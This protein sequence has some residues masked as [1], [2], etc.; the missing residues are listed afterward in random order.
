M[1]VAFKLQ[2]RVDG[3][4]PLRAK[5]ALLR[6]SQQRRI[7]RPAVA[8]AGT[9]VLQAARQRAP[10]ESGQLRRS[11]GKRVKLLRKSGIVVAI[12]GPRRKAFRKQLWRQSRWSKDAQWVNPT[13]YAHLVEF[14]TLPHAIG[15]GRRLVKHPGAR[16]RP[17]L[18]P[19]LAATR[20]TVL[21]ILTTKI[22][23]GLEKLAAAG[24]RRR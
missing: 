9:P 4:G 22:G 5:L 19:A 2:M 24:R 14:G 23:Q 17:F 13:N 15:V 6:A 3:L 8:A 16:A 12:V 18:R 20:G 10:V 21:A 11:L 1:Q 7:V